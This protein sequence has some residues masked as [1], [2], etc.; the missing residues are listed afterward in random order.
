MNHNITVAISLMVFTAILFIPWLNRP[1]TGHH[2]FVGAFNSQM[3]RNYLRYGLVTTKLGQVTNFGE[4]RPEEFAYHTHHPPGVPLMLALV[5]AIFGEQEWAARG[6]MAG[7]SLGSVWLYILL[8]SQAAPLTI[9]TM[10]A[11][12]MVTTPLFIYPSILPVYEAPALFLLL[13]QFYNFGRFAQTRRPKYWLIFI[14]AVI[15]GDVTAWVTYFGLPIL[16]A[17]EF[18]QRKPEFLKKLL[19]LQIVSI[20][21]FLLHLGHTKYLTGDWFG[22]GLGEIFL[23]RV[24]FQGETDSRYIYSN[25][26]YILKVADRL[27]NYYGLP[28]LAISTIGLV[29]LWTSKNQKLVNTAILLTAVALTLPVIFRNYVF[30]HDYTLFYTSPLIGFMA[31]LGIDQLVRRTERRNIY[32]IA[33]IGLIIVTILTTRSLWQDLRDSISWDETSLI[34]GRRIR[35]TTLPNQSVFVIN[36]GLKEE[37][38]NLGYYADRRITFP[39][40]SIQTVD[41]IKNSDAIVIATTDQQFRPEVKQELLKSYRLETD[42]GVEYYYR[43]WAR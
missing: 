4:A 28:L 19:L 3:A 5:Y 36:P 7:F 2:D 43:L 40:S 32:I 15:A 25:S 34:I 38:V 20:G 29:R 18:R 27:K 26:N 24:V 16:I 13:L 9:A 11:L 42:R 10:A 17:N 37:E 31:A 6:L 30:V 33:A 8:I 22:G 35:Q 21:F 1:F 12:I 23:K 39:D 41:S 14:L